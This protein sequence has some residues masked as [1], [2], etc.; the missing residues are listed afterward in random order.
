MIFTSDNG[1][2]VKGERLTTSLDPPG[3]GSNQPLR[4]AKGSTWEGG[5]GYLDLRWPHISEGITCK[6]IVTSMD[7]FPDISALAEVETPRQ[8]Y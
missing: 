4:G 1:S 7:P 3:F 2:R 6:E 8:T 5:L